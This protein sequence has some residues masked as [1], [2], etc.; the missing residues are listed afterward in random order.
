MPYSISSETNHC[1]T[2]SSTNR[3]AQIAPV[4]AAAIL[5][6][7]LLYC[8]GFAQPKFLHDAAHDVRHSFAFPCH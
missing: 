1:I 8:M 3:V 6:V 2:E 5:G 4:F 7:V